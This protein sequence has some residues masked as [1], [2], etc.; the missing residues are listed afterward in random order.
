[1]QKAGTAKASLSK[2]NP[3]SLSPKELVHLVD[4]SMASKY[5][6]DP[7]DVWSTLH[8]F[9]HDLD[10]ILRKQVRSV[11]KEVIG[12]TQGKHVVDTS[13]TAV[14]QMMLPLGGVGVTTGGGYANQPIIANLPQLY[15]QA[16]TYGPTFPPGGTGM[17]YG[18]WSDAWPTG[19]ANTPY[20]VNTDRVMSGEMSEGVKDKVTQRLQELGFSPKCQTKTYQKPYHGY[21]DSVPYPGGF[22]VFNFVKFTGENARTTYEHLG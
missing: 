4:A 10:D 18:L 16:T 14:P 22:T 15:Y 13:A 17:P 3:S 20:A 1:V 6:A 8:S 19:T 5:G 2:V 11:V 9:R 7:E 21:F 12:N